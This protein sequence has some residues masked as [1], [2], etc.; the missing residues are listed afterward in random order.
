M[1]ELIV[2]IMDVDSSEG[3]IVGHACGEA[4]VDVFV[5]LLPL[6]CFRFCSFFSELFKAFLSS[7]AN[8]KSSIYTSLVKAIKHIT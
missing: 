2:G 8:K 4:N 7:Y 5:F 6:L 3:V 1:C